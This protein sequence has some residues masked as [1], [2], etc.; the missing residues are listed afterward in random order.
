MTHKFSKDNFISYHVSVLHELDST[1]EVGH[2]SKV[3]SA[4]VVDP[5]KVRL[6]REQLQLVLQSFKLALVRILLLVRYQMFF[7]IICFS[8]P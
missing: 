2:L 1:R 7:G 5:S 8:L 4:P 3:G 6:L